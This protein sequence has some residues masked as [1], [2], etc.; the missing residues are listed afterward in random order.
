M[1]PT[2]DEF[3]STVIS[4]I[5]TNKFSTSIIIGK[6]DNHILKVKAYDF[7]S[8]LRSPVLTSAVDNYVYITEEPTIAISVRYSNL[9]NT[10]IS[11][12][13]MDNDTSYMIKRFL[14]RTFIKNEDDYYEIYPEL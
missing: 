12:Y 10:T 8:G 11:K 7:V 4:Y 9:Y 5:N 13:N 3:I 14:D 6:I 2:F 1:L